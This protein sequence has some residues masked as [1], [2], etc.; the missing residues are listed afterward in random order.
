MHKHYYS[1]KTMILR[2]LLVVLVVLGLMAWEALSK[3][4][5]IA[6]A[7]VYGYPLVMMNET[8]AAML[9]GTGTVNQLM[10]NQEFPD[11]SFRNVVR[12]NNDTLYSSAWLDLAAEP[13]ILSVPDTAGRY[14]VMPFMDAY[15]NVFATV[16]KRETGTAAGSYML[17]GPDWKGA[18]P[19]GLT[20]IRAPTNM[21]WMIGRIQTN[22]R[23]DIANV[24]QLQRGF[25]LYR[26]SQW[27]TGRSSPALLRSTSKKARE[28]DP[29]DT[30][31]SISAESFFTEMVRLMGHYPPPA[32]DAETLDSLRDLGIAAGQE[33]SLASFGL[34]GEYIADFALDTTRRKIKERI[35]SRDRLENGWAVYRDTIG[36]YGKEYGVRAAVAMIGLGALPPLEAVY[37]NTNIDSEGES[38]DG[39]RR[40]RLHFAAGQT[41]PVNAFWSLTMYDK[42]GFLVDNPIARYAIGD[43]DNLQYNAD[44]SL[45]LW[46]QRAEPEGRLSNWLPS[47]SGSFALTLR[48]YYPQAKFLSGEWRLPA[49]ERLP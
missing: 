19:D 31:N 21:V 14:Y 30:L 46:I 42:D 18:V 7:F 43:R 32:S 15:T 10:H 38:L 37:P 28:L 35:D 4:R 44:G 8:R 9:T 45:D 26:L 29:Y 11:H 49:I 27:P 5:A 1:V 36:N 34:I 48:L 16:G 3:T 6:A 25:A 2:I 39:S 41:P 17:L 22:G 20:A 24:A 13:L 40:Y 33:F 47:P 23:E 12:P